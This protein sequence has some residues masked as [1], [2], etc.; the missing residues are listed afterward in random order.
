MWEW[1]HRT[2]CNSNKT[3]NHP[4]WGINFI[5]G[6]IETQST[7]TA[8]SGTFTFNVTASGIQAM[9][10]MLSPEITASSTLVV[11]GVEIDT[12]DAQIDEVLVFNGTKF[13]PANIDTGGKSFAYFMGA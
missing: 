3:S 1:R 5:I 7:V 8:T 13:A 12:S 6:P 10:Q 4:R 9:T 2:T 11:Q